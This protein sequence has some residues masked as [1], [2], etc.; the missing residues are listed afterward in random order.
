MVPAP[1]LPEFA[2]AELEPSPDP[3]ACPLGSPL[4]EPPE[5]AFAAVWSAEAPLDEAS[6]RSES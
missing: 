2:L 4:A 1:L 6:V 5:E 3:L